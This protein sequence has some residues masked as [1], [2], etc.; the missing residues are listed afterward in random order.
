MTILLAMLLGLAGGTVGFIAG[1]LISGVIA[2]A[3]HM[4]TME[5]ARGYFAIAV[6]FPSGLIGMVVTIILTL[7]WR[8]VTNIAGVLGHSLAAVGGLV[9]VAAAG[10]GLYYLSIPHVIKGPQVL[11]KFEIMTPNGAETPDLGTWEAELNT[12]K[13]SMP[14]YWD[15][16]AHIEISGRPVAAGHA[17]SC[18]TAPASASSL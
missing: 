10:V 14:A 18:T 3:L 15:R 5:G 4:S 1:A 9:A 11:L 2:G 16:D 13:N 6:G 8:G 7:R 17:S 12:D